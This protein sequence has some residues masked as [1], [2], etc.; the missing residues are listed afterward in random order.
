MLHCSLGNYA[1]A[2]LYTARLLHL[3]QGSNPAINLTR[4]I[5]WEQQKKIEAEAR[6]RTQQVMLATPRQL[7]EDEQRLI[8]SQGGTFQTILPRPQ[9]DNGMG[10]AT[11][12]QNGPSQATLLPPRAS[13]TPFVDLATTLQRVS[14]PVERHQAIRPCTKE[15]PLRIA[16]PLIRLQMLRVRDNMRNGDK[17]AKTAWFELAEEMMTHFASVPEFNR[18]RRAKETPSAD[19]DIE[20][21]EKGPDDPLNT[22]RLEFTDERTHNGIMI[23]EWLHIFCEYALLRA[24]DGDQYLSYQVL[25]RAEGLL[26]FTGIDAYRYH[27]HVIWLASSLALDDNITVCSTAKWFATVIPGEAEIYQLYSAVNLLSGHQSLK[28]YMDPGNVEFFISQAERMD[29]DVDEAGARRDPSAREEGAIA[30][31]CSHEAPM[32]TLAEADTPVHQQRQPPKVR[33]EQAR[34]RAPQRP[35]IHLLMLIANLLKSRGSHAEALHYYLRVLASQPSVTPD[36]AEPI[37]LSDNPHNALPALCISTSYASL[38]IE[39]TCTDRNACILQ[40]QTFMSIYARLRV[41]SP[42]M[43][44]EGRDAPPLTEH[45]LRKR[46]TEVLF[47]EGRLYHGL[48]LTRQ[49]REKYEACLDVVDP[50]DNAG[51]DDVMPPKKDATMA[52]Q[53]IYAANGDTVRARE[54][55]EKYLV[56]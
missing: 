28:G 33:R 20:I 14:P 26:P 10:Q 7:T 39:K 35:N 53:R 11:L 5:G 18:R 31:S 3:K 52:L 38:A 27:I 23:R 9:P 45:V 8:A 49:A 34:V 54:V 16:A 50:P 19:A 51:E 30:T 21:I 6:R 41:R 32:P 46:Q 37:D 44:P 2:E 13:T 56:L 15:A 24:R 48:G 29:A 36:T 25:Q 42:S 43:D 22:S 55:A 17:D 47:N 4:P 12:G 1:R 40:A